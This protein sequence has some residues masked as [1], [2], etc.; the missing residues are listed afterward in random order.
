MPEF[1]LNCINKDGVKADF[2]YNNDISSLYDSKHS[3]VKIQGAR[4]GQCNSSPLVFKKDLSN[5]RYLRIKFTDQCNFRCSYC[6]QSHKYDGL[7]DANIDSFVQ[8][9]PHPTYPSARVSLWGGEPFSQW[10][11]FSHLLKLMRNIYP[12]GD[13][14]VATNGSLITHEIADF[15]SRMNI[16][17]AVSHDGPG[18]WQR[19]ANPLDPPQQQ[20][21]QYIFNLL[22][23]KGKFS[24]NPMLTSKNSSRKAINDWFLQE[25]GHS[26]FSLGEG[27]FIYPMGPEHYDLCF[28]DKKQI[29][30]YALKN[31]REIRHCQAPNMVYRNLAL[32]AFRDSLAEHTKS[33]SV[34]TVS[35]CG[36]H[37]PYRL[38][39]DTHGNVLTCQN[40]SPD[41]IMPS[42]KPNKLG[43]LGGGT[44]ID[45]H[46]ATWRDYDM[47][48]VCPILHLCQGG[49]PSNLGSEGKKLECNNNYADGIGF[50]ATVIEEVTGYLPY[51]IEGPLPE[52][53][54]EL[55][56]TTSPD[57]LFSM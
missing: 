11:M 49:C 29:Q 24:F 4:K 48:G 5:I 7:A 55:F 35:V 1:K 16:T 51:H 38:D 6:L 8:K 46:I 44:L 34:I 2:Y 54:K 53:R 14:Y 50:F 37:L 13:F 9:L 32:Q 15:L 33:D 47:C 25:I 40:F 36:I 26:Q 57:V 21:L 12:S 28:T 17:T 30:Q 56:G 43:E 20:E 52:D 45:A 42:G 19:G 31:L 23:S 41:H 3:E 27:K 22:N 10:G 39:V 18:Q